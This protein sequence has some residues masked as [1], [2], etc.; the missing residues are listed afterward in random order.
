MF[1]MKDKKILLVT[2]ASSEV[3][4]LLIDKV[5]VNYDK[6]LAHYRSSDEKIKEL[7]NKYGDKIIPLQADFA[8]LER[9]QA[10]I[11]SIKDSGNYPDHIVHLSAQ[12]A[13]NLQF[14][15]Q[16]WD[17]YQKEID[18]SLRSITMIIQQLIPYMSKQN[19]G[20][21]VFMLTAYL[22]EVPPKFQGPY[23]T[24]KYALLGM[25]KNLAAEYASK[26]IMVNAVSPDMMETKFLS[27]LPDLVKE[28]SAKNNPLGRN[29]Y[30]EEVIPTLMYLL[31]DASD[32]VTGQNIGVTGGIM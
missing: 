24:V 2:G 13:H 3:G 20:K 8:D 18:T 5:A 16:T 21:I 11:D 23:I 26:R 7:H 19:Y 6:V 28:Q 17:N 15:R 29:L 4:S 25:M 1:K 27:E 31:S 12:K 30:V 32:V 14:H 10:L 22:M 9:T